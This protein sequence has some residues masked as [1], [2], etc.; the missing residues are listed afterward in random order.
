MPR[1]EDYASKFNSKAEHR[2][3]GKLAPIHPISLFIQQLK[4]DDLLLARSLYQ[5]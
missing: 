3:L 1:Q 2:T 4:V 5:D